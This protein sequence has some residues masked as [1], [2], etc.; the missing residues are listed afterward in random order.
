MVKHWETTNLLWPRPR[1]EEVVTSEV[2]HP[3]R[4]HSTQDQDA[5]A[6]GGDVQPL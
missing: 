3:N 4:S 1:R 5:M 2:G 6:I